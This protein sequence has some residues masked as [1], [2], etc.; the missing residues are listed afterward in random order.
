MPLGLIQSLATL[1][2]LLILDIAGLISSVISMLLFPLNLFCTVWIEKN[3]PS[4]S[5]Y[6]EKEA[7]TIGIISALVLISSWEH[8]R[9]YLLGVLF[10]F[11]IKPAYLF[12]RS[13]RPRTMILNLFI[14]LC[15]LCPIFYI[16]T[17]KQHNNVHMEKEDATISF[18]TSMNIICAFSLI[19]ESLNSTAHQG[20][21]F[22]A[23]AVLFFVTAPTSFILLIFLSMGKIKIGIYSACKHGTL[24]LIPFFPWIVGMFFLWSIADS[25]R[26]SKTLHIER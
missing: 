26:A 25:I 2:L 22:E 4:Y 5:V 10:L 13:T 23:F 17:I 18:L 9:V 11:C 15:Y 3:D 7:L 14:V 21:G 24:L 16:F 1:L 8:T 20:F 6:I 12:A 19:L